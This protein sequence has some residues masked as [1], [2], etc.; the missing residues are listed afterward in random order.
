M[1]IAEITTK[2][3]SLKPRTPNH[4]RAAALKTSVDRAR[5]ELKAERQRQKVQKAQ[6]QLSKTL[7]TIS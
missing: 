3:K 2:A 1:R 5:D 4:A 7:A 6:Q